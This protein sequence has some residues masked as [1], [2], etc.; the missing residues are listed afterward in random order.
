MDN[1]K[2][3]PNNYVKDYQN[4]FLMLKTKH[5]SIAVLVSGLW[6]HRVQVRIWLERKWYWCRCEWV[7]KHNEVAPAGAV[8]DKEMVWV[9]MGFKILESFGLECGC[10]WRMKVATGSDAAWKQKRGT[11]KFFTTVS[12]YSS[13]LQRLSLRNLVLVWC[14]CGCG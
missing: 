6:Y 8:R 12:I 10:R 9:R 2:A 13:K 4:E 11:S 14:G 3:T 7:S 5:I 1:L